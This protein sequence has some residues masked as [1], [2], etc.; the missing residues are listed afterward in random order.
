[1]AQRKSQP[2]GYGS[3]VVGIGLAAGEGRRSR[4]LTLK[5]KGYLRSKGAIRLLGQRLMDWIIKTLVGEGVYHYIMVTK[6]KENRYQVKRLLGYG[7]SL[8]IQVRY[9]HTRFDKLDRGSADATLLNMEQFDVRTPTFVFPTDSI[10]EVDVPGLLEQHESRESIATILTFDVR[11]EDAIGKYGVIVTDDDGRV[12]EFVEKPSAEE[13]EGLIQRTGSDVFLTNA[14][15]YMLDAEACREVAGCSEIRR[16]RER[17]LDFGKDFL[18]WLAHN[19]YA[20]HTRPIGKVG[21]LG[22]IPA[23][24][25]TM[26][27]V[28]RGEFPK[29][30]A[31]LGYCYSRDRRIWI[32]PETLGAVDE[33]TGKT[34]E[35][36]IESGEVT[37]GRH[38]RIGKYVQIASGVHLDECNVDDECEVYADARISRSSIGEGSIIGP[39]AE[40]EDCVCGVMADVQSS[41]SS[42]THL[43]G[44]SA[45]GDEA[46]VRAGVM[47]QDGVMV[48]PRVKVPRGCYC[49]PGA[50]LTTSDDVMEWL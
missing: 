14:G 50:E 33:W 35:E 37:L 23:Y 38:V 16:M 46:V 11:A 3:D 34:L 13:A 8:G 20:I 9:S 15:F 47:L 44:Y 19:G 29:A 43:S 10:L 22:N 21:D 28:L 41:K 24:L 26:L 40:I 27:R 2:F 49:P 36:R 39:A 42:P 30:D 18:P 6:G 32:E 17:S 48:Y 1:V 7:E 31:Q 45:I 12:T 5:A 25:E 4:P